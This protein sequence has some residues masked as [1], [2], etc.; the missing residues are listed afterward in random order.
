[1]SNEY[2]IIWKVEDYDFKKLFSDIKDGK[3][4]TFIHQHYRR[5]QQTLPNVDDIVYI[6]NSGKILAK[7]IVINNNLKYT[8]IKDPY[9]KTEDFSNFKNGCCIQIIEIFDNLL[10]TENS[11]SIRTNWSKIK[12]K[13]FD[14]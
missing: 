7:A 8:N 4:N 14:L 6:K 9:D 10:G 11:K 3:H 2:L 13:D 1:M 5:N 12:T